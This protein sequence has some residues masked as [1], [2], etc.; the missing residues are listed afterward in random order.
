MLHAKPACR[1]SVLLISLVLLCAI[2]L[3]GSP[4]WALAQTHNAG[5]IRSQTNDTLVPV[6]VLHKSRALTFHHMEPV[7]WRKQVVASGYKMWESIA[8]AN[9]READFKLYEDGQEQQIQSVMPEYEDSDEYLA[10]HFD[11]YWQALGVGGGAWGIP[12]WLP[13]ANSER[14]YQAIFD[15]YVPSSP[16]GVQDASLPADLVKL[17]SLSWYMIAYV[18]PTSPPGS[19]HRITVKVDRS[20]SLV[21]SR[22]EYCDSSDS[23]VDALA[24]TNLGDRLDADL[25]SKKKSALPLT[26]TAIPVFTATGASRIRLFVDATLNSMSIGCNSFMEGSGIVGL[27]Y[28]KDGTLAQRFSDGLF[29]APGKNSM[30]WD[31]EWFTPANSPGKMDCSD[32]FYEPTRYQTQLSLPPGAYQL[33]IGLWNGY[34]FGRAELRLTVDDYD[35]T[36]LAIGGLALVQTFRKVGP[37]RKILPRSL[38]DRYPPLTARGIEIAP[39]ANTTFKKGFPFDFYL[40]VYEPQDVGAQQSTVLVHLQIRDAKTNRIV[41]QLEPLSA[42]PYITPGNRVIPIVSEIDIAKLVKGAYELEAQATDSTGAST[43]WR[44]ANFTIEK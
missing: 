18:P 15:S 9:L 42:A 35:S 26:I 33:K 38:A 11:R 36:K 25:L 20:D 17:P 39:V 41:K 8:V 40:Q 19:C 14:L 21:Y 24:G 31:T 7:A 27:T 37:N 16:L 23:A 44:T 1:A 5:A 30:Y 2:A 4:F 32:N 3:C 28:S 10:S 43:A 34:Q 12:D 22:S 29:Y 13:I 6:L